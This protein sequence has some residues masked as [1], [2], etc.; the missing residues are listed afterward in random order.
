MQDALLKGMREK[1]RRHPIACYL[2]VTYAVTWSAWFGLAMTGHV[3]T[4][5]LS[6]IYLLGLLGPLAGA[7]VATALVDGTTGLRDL[8]TRMLRVRVGLQWWGVAIGVPLAVAG[9]TYVLLVAYAVF[10]LAPIDLPNAHTFGMFVGYP[11]TN[12]VVL[13]VLLF[14]INGVGEEAGWRGFLL[15]TLQR[16]WSPLTASLLVAVAWVL[17]HAPAFLINAN[18]RAM[19]VAMLPLFFTGIVCGSLF[20]TWLYNRG[21]QSIALVAAWH[22]L[23]NLLSGSVA[24]TG[25]LAAVESMTVMAIAVVLI[26]RELHATQ[27]ERRGRPAHH[28]MSQ[29]SA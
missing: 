16:R 28:V 12:P 4:L 15:P 29:G 6:P 17:W 5:G 3:V 14:A 27:R 22:A 20:L 7:I 2:A 1:L 11:I 26:V 19:P 10:L 25:V 13:V 9:A 18:Y 23:Y 24:A 8:G 21:R